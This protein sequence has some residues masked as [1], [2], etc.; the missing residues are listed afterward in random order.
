MVPSCFQ[1]DLWSA[2]NGTPV[3]DCLA[4]YQR[5]SSS[6]LFPFRNETEKNESEGIV[7]DENETDSSEK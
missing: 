6:V 5:F 1:G 2:K 4:E 3:E 7:D